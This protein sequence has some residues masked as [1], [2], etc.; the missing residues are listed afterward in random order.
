MNYSGENC[1]VDLK[2]VEGA[3][4]G[5]GCKGSAFAPSSARKTQVVRLESFCVTGGERRIL[6]ENSYFMEKVKKRDANRKNVNGCG[7]CNL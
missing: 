6:Y 3:V 4:S 5:D 2:L 7:W 1:K